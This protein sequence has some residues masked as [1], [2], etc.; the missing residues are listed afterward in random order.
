[1]ELQ[2][3]S[4]R[5]LYQ[6]KYNKSYQQGWRHTNR[7]NIMNLMRHLL[8]TYILCHLLTPR[9]PIFKL[10]PNLSTN[11]RHVKLS[12]II[13][14]IKNKLNDNA[15][16]SG[17]RV[18]YYVNATQISAKHREG[19][20]CYFY[21]RRSLSSVCI[22]PSTAISLMF[23]KFY[24]CMYKTSHHDLF[25]RTVP[26]LRGPIRIYFP[27]RGV[28]LINLLIMYSPIKCDYEI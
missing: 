7:N 25:L 3:M 8:P 9:G 13:W 2:I 28:L 6:V 5:Y 21:R 16:N 27:N 24:N 19:G 22:S 26:I 11:I 17:F 23:G 4:Q 14:D 20:L 12:K 1:M 18:T 15:R 10:S